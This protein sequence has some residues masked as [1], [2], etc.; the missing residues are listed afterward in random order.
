MN[1][2]SI[3]IV[4]THDSG[5]RFAIRIRSHELIV[6]QT[7]AGGG[8]DSGPTPIELL[9]ASLGSCIAYYVHHFF[10]T[11]GLPADAIRV[12][13]TQA[14]ESN[15]NRVGSFRAKVFLPAEIPSRYLTLLKRVIDACPAHN[16]LL[17]GAKIHVG[18]ETPAPA[19]AEV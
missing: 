15:P 13:V 17:L 6:D 12:E 8:A 11:R 18:F 4:V 19:L 7:L 1:N 5:V 2:T 3:P 16:T 9:G 14:G 10:H